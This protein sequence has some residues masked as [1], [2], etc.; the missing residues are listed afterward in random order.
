MSS[1][2]RLHRRAVAHR[3]ASYAVAYVE[4]ARIARLATRYTLMHVHLLVGM[5]L[6]ILRLAASEWL[7]RLRQSPHSKL[8][9][10]N[11]PAR[12]I[13]ST[14]DCPLFMARNIDLSWST[15]SIGV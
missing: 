15:D 1:R 4:F 13:C 12:S 7:N 2:V 10:C 3:L 9:Y 8:T 6:L 11:F 5:D 14:I